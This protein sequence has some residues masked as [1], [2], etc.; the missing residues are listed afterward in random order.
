MK[1]ILMVFMATFLAFS[2][3]PISQ[4]FA[5]SGITHY[6]SYTDENGLHFQYYRESLDQYLSD[7]VLPEGWE[8]RSV[9]PNTTTVDDVYSESYF[10]TYGEVVYFTDIYNSDN[11]DVGYAH[12]DETPP[13]VKVTVSLDDWDFGSPSNTPVV[14][15]LIDGIQVDWKTIPGVDMLF[16]YVKNI[17]GGKPDMEFLMDYYDTESMNEGELFELWSQFMGVPTDVGDYII[18]ALPL[19]DGKVYDGA[20]AMNYFKINSVEENGKG[21]EKGTPSTGN[22]KKGTSTKNLNTPKTGDIDM[23]LIAITSMLS[24]IGFAYIEKRY[25]KKA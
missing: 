24:A 10:L 9:D 25:K 15:L 22:D 7:F 23:G 6:D 17:W 8:W 21:T 13:D 14:E 4:V 16:L 2:F 11:G 12:F 1:K 18:V 20:T 3:M 5:G 19:V